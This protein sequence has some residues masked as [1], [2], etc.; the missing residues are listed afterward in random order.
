MTE[1]EAAIWNE[2]TPDEMRVVSEEA[3]TAVLRAQAAIESGLD[4]GSPDW[5][6]AC[7]RAMRKPADAQ[8]AAAQRAQV[9]QQ[10]DG[11]PGE[12]DVP[13]VEGGIAIIKR[14]R[15]ST[16]LELYGEDGEP[17]YGSLPVDTPVATISQ[18]INL[19]QRAEKRGEE[20][21]KRAKQFELLAVLGVEKPFDLLKKPDD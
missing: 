5:R 20:W 7:G 3:I 12:S 10:T 11:E 19:I 13:G 21:G 4:Y 2:L 17:Y 6:A 18:A 9:A 1:Q 16:S 14:G 15:W 8:D